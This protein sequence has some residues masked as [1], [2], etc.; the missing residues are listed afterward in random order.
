MNTATRLYE[1]YQQRLRQLQEKDCP[2]T[3]ETQTGWRNGGRQDTVLAERSR[4]VPIATRSCLP[5]VPATVVGRNSRKRNCRKET[6][7]CVHMG[8]G[9]V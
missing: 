8:A 9:T 5:N 3:D 4:Y 7:V 1:E 6:A 2:H